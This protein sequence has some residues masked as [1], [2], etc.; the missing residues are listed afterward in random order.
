MTDIDRTRP[1]RP[2]T[3]PKARTA[4]ALAGGLEALAR[5]LESGQELTA[6]ER[7]AAARRLDAAAGYIRD[8]TPDMGRARHAASRDRMADALAERMRESLEDER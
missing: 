7:Q 5:R 1:E 8:H 3:E 4:T 2:G 6:A